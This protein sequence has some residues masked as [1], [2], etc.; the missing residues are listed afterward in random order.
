[1]TNRTKPTI[2]PKPSRKTKAALVARLI[3]REKGATVDEIA[4]ATAWQSHSCRA[5]LTGLRKKGI[6][7]VKEERGDGK[8]AYRTLPVSGETAAALGTPV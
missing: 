2:A 6:Q 1:M 5:F 7:L 8:A 3:S 4:K